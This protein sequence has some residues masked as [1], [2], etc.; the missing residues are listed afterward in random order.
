MEWSVDQTRHPPAIRGAASSVQGFLPSEAF[1]EHFDELI[2]ELVSLESI[3]PELA[4][5]TCERALEIAGAEVGDIRTARSVLG[6]PIVVSILRVYRQGDAG[7]RERCL[8]VIDRL[9][10]IDAYG[11]AEALNGER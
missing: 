7:R 6:Q 10:E 8:D 5:R 11:L 3:D 9:S 4:L 1:E 2:R